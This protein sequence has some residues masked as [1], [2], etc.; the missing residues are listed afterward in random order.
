MEVLPL[1]DA[2]VCIVAANVENGKRIGVPFQQRLHKEA[3]VKIVVL[4]ND[5]KGEV[6]VELIINI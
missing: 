4:P 5:S 6:L 3:V 1:V 2:G